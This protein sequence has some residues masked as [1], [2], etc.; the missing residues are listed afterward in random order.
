M[1]RFD[2]S[3]L[4]LLDTF[5]FEVDELLENLDNILMRTEKGELLE[6]D[7]AEIFR[8]MHTI[9]GSAAMMGLQNMSVLAH[10]MEDLFFIIRENPEV[11][12]E[13]GS[14]YE[15]L[16]TASDALKNEMGIITDESTQ[17]TDFSALIQKIHAYADVMKGTEVQS[18][19]EI[20]SDVFEIF[21]AD[22]ADSVLTFKVNYAKNCMMASMRAMLLLKSV[23]RVAKVLYTL[24]RDLDDENATDFILKNGLYIKLEADDVEAVLKSLNKGLNVDSAEQ[25]FRRTVEIFNGDSVAKDSD[26]K[27]LDINLD[28]DKNTESKA[29]SGGDIKKSSSNDDTKKSA[30]NGGF[31]SVK[32]EKLDRL[33]DLVSEIVITE[34][35][36]VSSPDLKKLGGNLEQFSKSARELKKLTDDLQ[37]VVMSI[38]MVPVASA[39]S[40]MNRVVRDMNKN[41]G[42][43][44][45][46]VFEGE[47][48]EVDKAV[49][50]ILNDPLMHIVR[51][52]IDHGIESP[53]QRA[54]SGKDEPAKV[55]LSAGYESSEV[56]ISCSDNGAG[57][58]AKKLLQKAKAKGILTKPENEYTDEDCYNLVMAAGFSTN[59]QVTEYSGRGV[60]MDVVR[61]NIEKVGGKISVFSKLGYG[62]KFVIKIPLSLSIVDVLGI[63]VGTSNFS[64]P[65]SSVVEVFSADEDQI[66]LDPEGSE[67][68]MIRGKCLRVIRLS[69]VFKI[70]TDVDRLTE[71]IM[72]Y[73]MEDGREAVIFGDY[74]SDD[75][76]VVVKPF[77]PLL[78]EYNL[79]KK[80][81]SGCS[82]LADG[83]ITLIADIS[84]IFIANDIQLNDE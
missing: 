70:H 3:L 13:K 71:G 24:P 6:E 22:E 5:I 83:S 80:G 23:G 12:Y 36:V 19:E 74:L 82:I 34:S 61:K 56:V 28:G 47:S 18:A 59:E 16:F 33:L 50:D 49:V 54:K 43:N 37:D 17:L 29:K 9:K 35:G 2:E 10:S 21:P 26:A 75:Q 79:K 38:R 51:N 66:I 14:L 55:I 77:S 45:T 39:F 31:I 25:V 69:D 53:E 48:T 64:I 76:Q 84:K 81:L 8:I 63:D 7:I 30:G 78:S 65:I 42:K 41:L 68:V 72:L 32:L 40:K 73:C 52:A 67:L 58:D 44:V 46:L 1:A 57:M 11:S 15:I 4:P 20:G 27:V 62:S 60:G